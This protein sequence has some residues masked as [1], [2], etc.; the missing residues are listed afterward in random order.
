LQIAIGKWQIESGPLQFAVG[1]LQFAISF[2]RSSLY[3]T[4][5]RLFSMDFISLVAP[6]L[7]V[8]QAGSDLKLLADFPGGSARVESID[9]PSRTIRVLPYPHKDRGWVC[10]WYFK[11]EGIRPGETLTLDVGGGV[12]ATPDQAVF[13]TDNLTW[14]QTEPGKREKDRI[15]YRVKLDGKEAWFAWGPPFVLKHAQELVQKWAKESPHA[16]AFELTRSKEGRAV[17]GLRVQQAGAEDDD[18]VGIWINARQ[19]AW[20]AGSSWVCK[21]FTDWLLSAEP[22]AEALRK[23]ARLTIVPIMDVDNVE[24]GAGGKNQKPHDHNRDWSAKPVWPEVEAAI[25]QIGELN[26]TGRF[27]LFVD[28]HNPGANDRQPFFFIPATELMSPAARRNL[29]SFLTAS[30]TEI[31]GPLKLNPKPRE[32]GANYDPNWEKISANWVVKHSKEHVVALCL[33]TSWNTP[34]STV[35]GYERVGKELGKAIERYFREG[36]RGLK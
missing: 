23:K 27:D 9:Q 34:Q 24:T 2:V 22:E 30:R 3:F 26:K 15:V 14:K 32:S 19:H 29:D 8:A 21:G 33:E 25:K 16:T 7:V 20:E 10:W 28:L 6:L 13:S 36:R 5:T 1:Y 11:V 12:W 17:P 35:V 31:T 4:M 18:R